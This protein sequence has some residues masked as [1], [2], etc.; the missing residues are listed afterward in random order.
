MAGVTAGLGVTGPAGAAPASLGGLRILVVGGTALFKQGAPAHTE[1]VWTGPDTE[2]EGV[3]RPEPFALRRLPALRRALDRSEFDLV[4]GH[5]PRFAPWDVRRAM[6]LLRRFRRRGPAV[7]LRSLGTL[8]L[9][10]PS[11]V[12]LAAVDLGDHAVIHRHNLA[13]LARA[14]VYFKRELPLDRAPLLAPLGEGAG[15]WAAKLAPISLAVSPLRRGEI[16]GAV[17]PPAAKTVDVFFAG[18]V[19]SCPAVRGPGRAALAA[20][21]AAGLRVDL[22]PGRLDR[23]EFYRRCARA[24]ITWS[25][26]GLG[27]DCFRHYEAPLCGS[28]PLMNAPSIVRHAPLEANV[29]GLYYDL[30]PGALADRVR[31]AL[32]DRARLGAIAAAGR[33]HV[34]RHHTLERLCEHVARACLGPAPAPGPDAGR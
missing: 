23:P 33:A 2:V 30:A 29:H 27:W 1:L 17:V 9:R 28:V 3:G 18:R 25:P 20:L 15:R 12:P 14:R 22:P 11:P 32:A 24:W 7:V 6:G 8:L 5:P 13:L 16:E 26:A 10:R 21:G 31:A 19:A 4:V 34:L